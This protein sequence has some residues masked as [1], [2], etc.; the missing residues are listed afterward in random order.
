MED[1]LEEAAGTISWRSPAASVAE[2]PVNGRARAVLYRVRPNAPT[3]IMLHALMSVSDAGYRHWARRFNSLGWNA[4]FVHLPFHYSRRPRGHLTGELCCTADLVLTGD[5]LRQ[6]VVE[7]RQLMA[8]LR[9][10]GGSE[11]GLLGTSYGGW[12]AALLGSREPDLRFLALLAPMVNISHA[13]YEGPTS[14]TI[15][16]HLL[17]AGLDRTLIER[18]AH[19]S[20]PLRAR[21]AGDVAQRTVIIGGA[22]DRI[23]RL[24]DLE[25]LSESWPGAELLT[26]PQAHFGYGMIPQAMAWLSAR[27]LLAESASNASMGIA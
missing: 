17:R 6:A 8:W 23:V 2:F 22:F 15:R 1:L 24:V 20:S 10:E 19:L 14:W 18:H 21:P 26:L 3:V 5:T 16:G 11:F 4:V 9:A 7:I 25:A 13:L 27:G 12:V